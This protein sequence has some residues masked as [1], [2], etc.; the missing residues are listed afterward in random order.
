MSLNA[1]TNIQNMHPGSRVGIEIE[2]CINRVKYNKLGY[3]KDEEYTEFPSTF[4]FKGKSP[5]KVGKSTKYG[6]PDLNNILLVTD[7]TCMCEDRDKFI[8]AEIVS[9]KMDYL[10]IPHYFN[11]LK[12]RV[13]NNIEKGDVLQGNTCGIHIH[14]SNND[15]D[16]VKKDINYKFLFFKFMHNLR[17]KL[18]YKLVNKYFTGKEHIYTSDKEKLLFIYLDGNDFKLQDKITKTIE[19]EIPNLKNK[20]LSDITYDI[21]RTMIKYCSLSSKFNTTKLKYKVIED[22]FSEPSHRKIII[23][24]N[25]VILKKYKTYNTKIKRDDTTIMD[26]D[27]FHTELPGIVNDYGSSGSSGSSGSKDAIAN[28]IKYI[29]NYS[30]KKNY[31]ANSLEYNKKLPPN[32][33]KE[34]TQIEED[35][36]LL[37]AHLQNILTVKEN[38]I[39]KL[40]FDKYIILRHHMSLQVDNYYNLIDIANNFEGLINEN[41][42]PIYQFRRLTEQNVLDL[43]L[44][45]NKKLPDLSF[46][47]IKDGFHMELRMYSLDHV[48]FEKKSNAQTLINELTKFVLYTENLMVNVISILNLAYDYREFSKINPKYKELVDRNLLWG[49]YHTKSQQK[50]IFRELFGKKEVD[51]ITSNKGRLSEV[52]LITSNKGRLSEVDLITSGSISKRGSAKKLLSK[53]SIAKKLLS[54]KSSVKKLLS[55]KLK[56]SKYNTSSEEMQRE[57]EIYKS[58]M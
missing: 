25:E 23:L 52:N 21:N 42:A 58:T 39:N 41:E 43:L 50:R 48:F 34:E 33:F 2:M 28:L 22:F 19:I 15:L 31:I 8:N 20:S 24:I 36:F 16:I 7:S 29:K 47:D 5:F 54:K 27:Y 30:S 51:L 37:E 11:F 10:E 53:K 14:W 13:F 9:P 1:I 49:D 44:E 6:E 3:N 17:T 38:N 40:F 4:K 32:Y 46:Y 45:S 26:D 57:Y 55:K 12:T 56:H 18:D 35:T